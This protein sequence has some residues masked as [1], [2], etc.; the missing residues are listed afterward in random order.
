MFKKKIFA[1]MAVFTFVLS[2]AST[3]LAANWIWIDSTDKISIYFDSE[4]AH[5]YEETRDNY[6]HLDFW[7]KVVDTEGNYTIA[8]ERMTHGYMYEHECAVY[9]SDGNRLRYID[10]TKQRWRIIP[11]SNL[12]KME[13]VIVSYVAGSPRNG[14]VSPKAP[15]GMP[16]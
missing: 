1:M 8:F 2:M 10:D 16:E 6:A 11:G 5:Y 15:K 9:D 3:C 4:T 12:V 14:G 13:T 7:V